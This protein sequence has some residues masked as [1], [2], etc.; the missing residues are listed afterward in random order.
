MMGR[1]VLSDASFIG[2]VGSS[3]MICFPKKKMHFCFNHPCNL[4]MRSRSQKGRSLKD[5]E[6]C[7]VPEK[8]LPHNGQKSY[9]PVR[10]DHLPNVIRKV[11]A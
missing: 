4:G 1:E 7:G 6:V 9:Q 10:H 2:I 8:E 11:F 3:M 5:F